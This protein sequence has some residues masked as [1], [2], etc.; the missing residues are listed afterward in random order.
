[1]TSLEKDLRKFIKGDVLFDDVNRYIYSFGASIYKIKPKGIVM[2]RDGDDVASLV[3]YASEHRIPLTARGTCTSLAGQA[4]GNGLIID[5]T[6]YMNRI[7]EYEGGETVRVEPGLVYGEL[8]RTLKKFDKYFPPDPSSG[9]YCTIGGMIANN[10]GGPH[11]VK[12]GNI[13]NWC[14]EL[15]VVLS[16]GDSAKLKSSSNDSTRFQQNFKSDSEI[17]LISKALIE[18]LNNNEA[19]IKEYTPKVKRNASGYNIYEIMKGNSLDLVK[20]IVGC[21]GTLAIITEA[22]LRLA[23]LPKFRS[24]LLLFLKDR[25][26]LGELICQLQKFI[27]A[28]VEF[29]DETFLKLA[30][31]VEPKL[32]DIVPQ[33]SKAVFLVEFEEEVESNLNEKVEF[34]K[35]KL[36]YN[37]ALVSDIKIAGDAEEQERLWD[38][39]RA[40]VPI[41]NR[42]RGKKRPIPFI[43]DPIVPP[44]KLDEFVNAAYGIFDRYSVVACVYG[45]AGEGNMHIR[46][47]LDMKDKSD[48]GKM[49]SMADEFYEMVLAL[50]G[51]TTAE[52][53][54]GI[55]RVPYIKRQFGSLYEVFKEIKDIFDPKGILNPGKKIGKYNSI[56]HDLI[57][58]AEFKYT[59][60]KTLFDSEQWRE[61]IEKCHACGLC[62]GAC[63]INRILPEEIASPRAKATLLRGITSGELSSSL[64]SAPDFKDILELCFNC[65]SCRVECPTEADIPLLCLIAKENFVRKR[66]SPFSQRLLEDLHLLG[67]ASNVV[68]NLSVLFLKTSVGKS[69]LAFALGIDKRRA[70]PNLSV[71]IFERRRLSPRKGKRKVVY[72]YGCYVNF[73]N[74]ENE[75]LS[76]IRILQKND[77]EVIL[78]PQRCCGLPSISTGDAKAVK[79]DMAYNLK[80]LYD[81]VKAGHDIITSCPSCGL[82]LKEDYPRILDTREARIVAQ[83][84]YDINEYL[85]MLFDEGNLNTNFK[86][87]TKNIAFHMPCHLIA[88]GIGELQEWMVSLIPGISIMKVDDSCCGMAGT[89]GLKA[90]NYDLSMEIGKALFREIKTASPDYVVT[91]CGACKTQIEGATSFKVA[92]PI[93][94]LA[95]SY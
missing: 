80:W 36:L 68:P 17:G 5:F 1:M 77:I 40:A 50:G 65:K 64:L 37:L 86:S 61:E 10:S 9:D 2:P 12:C 57:Y 88:Q 52:H 33:D 34:V 53:G 24:V 15:E 27:P 91:S 42:L 29:M 22:K 60:T 87:S 56:M 93:H 83:K 20:L 11:S 3:K 8:N 70:I 69:L 71:P 90:K 74:A 25:T 84:T 28:A 31:E 26:T 92:H 14:E 13:A 54:D 38:V 73:Y 63:P 58:D 55:L 47:L 35:Q 89:Y 23:D 48:L 45:H 19:Q 79:K 21:E 78:P 32:R 18:L 44:E 85:W 94:L 59:T 76:V 7:L 43:E 82:A 6:K 46:P 49:D 81:A 41:M 4:V 39:R 66:G 51:S 67:S 16:T 75:G 72:F 95:E 30:R 62:R